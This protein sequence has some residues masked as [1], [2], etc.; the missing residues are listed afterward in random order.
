MQH[1]SHIAEPSVGAMPKLIAV[2]AVVLGLCAI[3]AYVV[4]GSG[5]WNPPTAQSSY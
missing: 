4:Y 2:L 1:Q 3:G 5:M